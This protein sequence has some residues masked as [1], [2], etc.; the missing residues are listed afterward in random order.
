ME[1]AELEDE[2]EEQGLTLLMLGGE[3]LLVDEELNEELQED[4][5]QLYV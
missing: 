3:D 4:V 2:A 1:E 5:A